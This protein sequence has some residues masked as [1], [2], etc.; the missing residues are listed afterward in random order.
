MLENLSQ[1]ERKRLK[2]I[3]ILSNRDKE[4][5]S[6]RILTGNGVMTSEELAIVSE[7][8]KKY[9][10]GCAAL[11]TRM[12]IEIQNIPYENIEPLCHF[13]ESSGLHY[14]GTGARIRPV[15]ACKGT[16]CVFGLVDTQ[17]LA[18]KIHNKYYEG[19][20]GVV[21]P[22]KFKIAVGGC[23]NNCVKPDLNDFGV[24][25]RM[26][27]GKHGYQVYLGGRWGKS[28]RHGT[29]LDAFYTTPEEVFTALEKA[30][31][32]FREQAYQG[33]RFGQMM[34]RIG[35]ENAEKHILSND[36]LSRKEQILASPLLQRPKA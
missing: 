4:H 8:A 7:A 9:G 13:I 23:P 17:E 2:G 36:I 28:T 19:W 34:E 32:L 6:M 21:L 18:Q 24:T 30:L 15:M 26:K 1:D 35:T 27:D 31:L 25:G 16:V 29:M 33:E 11:T 5:F 20:Y 10:D 22:H 3:G 14:G 12:T